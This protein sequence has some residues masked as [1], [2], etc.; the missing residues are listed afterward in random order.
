M[1]EIS[2]L[3]S[4][5]FEL[6]LWVLPNFTSDIVDNCGRFPWAF[7][8]KDLKLVLGWW[9]Y[10]AVYNPGLMLLLVIKNPIFKE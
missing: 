6:V 8:Q 3:I 2:G 7:S 1:I 10:A 9:N 5:F 4:N